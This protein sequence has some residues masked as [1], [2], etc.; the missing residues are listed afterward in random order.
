MKLKYGWLVLVLAAL[1]VGCN[2]GKDKEK[3][4]PGEAASGK[5]PEAES[6]VKHGTNGEVIVTVEAKLQP[7]I[8]LQIAPLEAAQLSPELKAYGH[9]LDPAP[10]AGIVSELATAETT[11]QASEAELRRL[12]TLAAQNNASERALQAAQ[13]AAVRDQTQVHAVHLRLLTGWGVAIAQRNDLPDFVMALGSLES[14]LAELELPAGEVLPA[15]PT[16]ARVFTLG[17]ETNP[18]PAELLGPAPMVDPQMQ[19]RGF[20]LLISPSRQKLVPGAALTGLLSLAGEPHPGVLLP[21][22]AVVRF[23][24]ATWVYVQTGEE[25]FERTEVTLASPLDNGWFVSQG[26][27][28]AQKVVTVGGQ[29]LLSEELKGQMGGEE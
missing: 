23:N 28:P 2:Q 20:L 1:A 15:E 21:R 8:G 9:V 10:L 11:A 29:E 27:K 22:S 4:E 16:E 3:K 5:A 12:K 25:T 18:L 17:M 13:A 24:G 6:H 14:A 19:G 7:T 26:L